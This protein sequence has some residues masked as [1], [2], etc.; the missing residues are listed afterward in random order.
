MGEGT[1]GGGVTGSLGTSAREDGSEVSEAGAG[2]GGSRVG[3]EL[4][5]LPGKLLSGEPRPPGSEG[6]PQILLGDHC[7]GVKDAAD[8][9]GSIQGRGREGSPQEGL[10]GDPGG[11]RLGTGAGHG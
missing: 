1:R 11:T 5:G 9:V 8:G 10:G 7:E 6:V 3:S 4:P 2:E